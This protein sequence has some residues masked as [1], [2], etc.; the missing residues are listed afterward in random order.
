MFLRIDNLLT[1]FPSFSLNANLVDS[2]VY[3][4]GKVILDLLRELEGMDEFK[5]DFLS[6]II[7]R[8]HYYQ[9]GESYQKMRDVITSSQDAITYVRN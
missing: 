9:K 6:M 2:N 7:R 4:F 1:S 8:Q 3:I 5:T